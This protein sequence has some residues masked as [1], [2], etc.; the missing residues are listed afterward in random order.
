MNGKKKQMQK[1]IKV[2]SRGMLLMNKSE[3]AMAAF[4]CLAVGQCQDQSLNRAFD[5]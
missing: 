4:Y 5:F 1:Y 3:V 2:L